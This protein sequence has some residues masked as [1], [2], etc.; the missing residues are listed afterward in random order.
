MK[1]APVADVKARL[2]AYL[3]MCAESPVV[4]TKNGRP[5]A[6]LVAISDEEDLERLVLAHTPR[7]RAIL[8]AEQRQIQEGRV[9]THREFWRTVSER[10]RKAEAERRAKRLRTASKRAGRTSMRV[11]AEFAALEGD[12][13]G[14]RHR[15]GRRDST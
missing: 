14:T 9:L 1:I 10:H 3:E 6:L 15:P 12:P 11:N 13:A 5:A 8:D 7:F 2:S 4:V